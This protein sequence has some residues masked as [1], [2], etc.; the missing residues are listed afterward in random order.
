MTSIQSLPQEII[1]KIAKY[2]APREIL[3][4]SETAKSLK[5]VRSDKNIWK[6]MVD[7]YYPSKI[8][9]ELCRYEI[10]TG[11]LYV[12]NFTCSRIAFEYIV[13]NKISGRRYWYIN[14]HTQQKSSAFLEDFSAIFKSVTIDIQQLDMISP[15]L[16]KKQR[17][18]LKQMDIPRVIQ[19]ILKVSKTKGLIDYLDRIFWVNGIQCM[20]DAISLAYM[21]NAE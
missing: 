7:K 3:R 9:K 19:S 8:V 13:E 14:Q 5:W 17:K 1:E 21:E 4:L 18:N 6:H 16:D 12:E 15:I 10:I 20:L 11:L 2:S